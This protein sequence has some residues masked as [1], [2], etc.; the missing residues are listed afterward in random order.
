MRDGP[1]GTELLRH[2]HTLLLEELMALLTEDRRYQARLV[3]DAMAI[4]ARERD[5]GEGP[6]DA[7]LEVLAGIYRENAARPA[8]AAEDLEEAL[9]RLN[10]R[11]AAEI[12]GGK[13]DAEARVYDLLRATAIARLRECNPKVLEEEGLA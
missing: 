9:L 5:A 1:G 12:R 11:L 3:A 13:R 2:A 7:E 10:W 8:G 6:L 4:A